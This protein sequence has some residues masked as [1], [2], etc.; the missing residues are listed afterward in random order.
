MSKRNVTEMLEE[1]LNYSKKVPSDT[2]GNCLPYLNH[3]DIEHAKSLIQ[4]LISN[5]EDQY[6]EE[7]PNAET[8]AF[9]DKIEFIK[10]NYH[11]YL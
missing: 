3:Y 6:D 8:Q 9:L 10:N 5:I 1:A 11:K 7:A 2:L 4:Y